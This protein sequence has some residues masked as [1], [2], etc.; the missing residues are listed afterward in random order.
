LQP[1]DVIKFKWEGEEMTDA[2]HSGGYSIAFTF[3]T[4]VIVLQGVQCASASLTAPS[5]VYE[6][7]FYGD[8][9][10]GAGNNPPSGNVAIAHST[11]QTANVATIITP[12]NAD[13]N[14]T[15]NTA[16]AH[17]PEIVL[18]VNNPTGFILNT[19]QFN[20]QVFR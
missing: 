20:V 19:G 18:Q 2:S 8:V 6:G 16:V 10:I 5:A 15:I 13:N 7:P 11:C 3:D 17:V 4:S 12:Q 1:G 9:T 14:P